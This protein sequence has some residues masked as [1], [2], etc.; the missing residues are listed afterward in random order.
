MRAKKKEKKNIIHISC[1]I[2]LLGILSIFRN[3]PNLKIKIIKQ[4][5]QIVDTFG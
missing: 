1:F 3:T 5:F 2:Q 4:F